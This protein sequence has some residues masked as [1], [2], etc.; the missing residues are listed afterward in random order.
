MLHTCRFL[1][2]ELRKITA[3]TDDVL[4]IDE[5]SPTH[6][7]FLKEDETKFIDFSNTIVDKEFMADIDELVKIGC[8][9]WGDNNAEFTLTAQGL[10][11][12]EKSWIELKSFLINSFLVPAVVAFFTALI[13]HIV[14]CLFS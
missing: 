4:V 6:R 10:H 1:L 2:K 8:L 13:T 11:P 12:Y 5:W 7:I 3:T 9:K 14:A